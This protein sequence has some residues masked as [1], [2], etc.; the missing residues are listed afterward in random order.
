MTFDAW[1]IVACGAA[2]LSIPVGLLL[3]ARRRRPRV[4]SVAHDFACTHDRSGL[5][6]VVAGVASGGNL[7]TGV[8]TGVVC[9]P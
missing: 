6:R 7:L 4:Q 1:L 8:Y 5:C 3:A 2:Y 9:G